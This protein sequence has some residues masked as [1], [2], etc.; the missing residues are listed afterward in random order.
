LRT[1]DRQVSKGLQIHMILDNHGTHT[2]DSVP[3]AELGVPS[4]DVGDTPT[5]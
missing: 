1:I 2:H 4:Q 5:R 3:D